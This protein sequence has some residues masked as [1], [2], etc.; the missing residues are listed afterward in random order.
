MSKQIK[1]LQ[2]NGI[3]YIKISDVIEIISDADAK[4]KQEKDIL[5]ILVNG[6]SALQNGPILNVTT[7]R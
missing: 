2:Y 6:F 3:E 7:I 4:T 1:T 5:L